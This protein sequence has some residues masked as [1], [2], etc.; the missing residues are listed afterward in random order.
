MATSSE[1]VRR[2]SLFAGVI[3]AFLWFAYAFMESNAFS[4][5]K[6]DEWLIV[7][8]GLVVCFFVPFLFVRAAAWVVGGFTSK[9]E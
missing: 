2:L 8:G 1:G 7:A 5:I 4:R 6:P 9:K 3:G